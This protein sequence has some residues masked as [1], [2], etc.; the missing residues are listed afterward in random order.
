MPSYYQQLKTRMIPPGSGCP[1]GPAWLIFDFLYQHIRQCNFN[2][3]STTISSVSLWT[4]Y[5][6]YNNVCL[7]FKLQWCAQL[8]F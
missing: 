7:F 5:L 6:L 3:N 4:S 1:T 8:N 2:V